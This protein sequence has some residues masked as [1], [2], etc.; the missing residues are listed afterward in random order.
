M[1]KRYLNSKA[2]WQYHDY[3][4]ARNDT[5]REIK[6]AKRDQERKIAGKC[7]LNPKSF[8]NY[9]NSLRKN[10]EYI[11]VLETTDGNMVTEDK[12]KAEVLVEFFTSVLTNENLQTL[13]KM[14]K[15]EKSDGITTA[16]LLITEEA[17]KIKLSKLNPNKSPGP[18]KLYPRVLKE[19]CNEL[20]R[21]L[22]YLYNLSIQ[23][24]KLP[25]EWKL[26]EVTPIFKKGNKTNP[27]NYRPVALTCILCKILE[28]FIRDAIQ[29]HMEIYKLYSHCQ[30]GF[31]KGKSCA[32]QLLRV[33]DDFSKLI[34]NGKSFDTLYLDFRKAFDAVP[35][36]RLL[37]KLNAYGI[38][39]QL[40]KWV[41]SFLKHRKQYVRMGKEHSEKHVITSG[42]PQGSIL[43]PILFLIFINDLPENIESICHV[44][45]DDTKIYNTTENKATLQNDLNKLYEWSEKWQLSFNASKC[46]CIHYGS[47]NPKYT[48]KIE[49]NNNSHD[50]ATASEEKDLGVVFDSTLKFDIH[51]NNIVTK[52][53][54]TLGIIKRNFNY[55]DNDVFLQL[56]KA[57]VRPH[58]EYAQSVWSP[59]LK[60]QQTLIENVQRRATKLVPYLTKLS[61]KERLEK[62]KLPSLRYRRIR[63]DLIQVFKFCKELKTSQEPNHILNFSDYNNTR[64]HDLK[65]IKEHY[66]TN[67]RKFSFSQR[68]VNYWNILDTNTVTAVDTDTFKKLMDHDLNKLKYVID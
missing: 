65:L 45:A 20:A 27:T 6:K 48:Y 9:I 10:K 23:S 57:L 14:T 41:S 4:K 55:F 35:H 68:V 63:G 31:R 17:V 22:T 2:S 30:H 40:H 7:K 43:G 5:S 8:W 46:K 1:F 39:G 50:I 16:D 47:K 12:D 66:E 18:D 67:I 49:S 19:I 38:T 60:R 62:L 64:G 36:E 33:M 15:A 11:S 61:Y 59:Y 42:I 52:A 56:Y 54:Q 34:D 29:E 58:L 44:F 32:T 53:N 26:S 25:D 13:P 21:P 28:S 37:I 24:G 3:I 51:I